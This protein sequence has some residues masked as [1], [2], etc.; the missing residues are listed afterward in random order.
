MTKKS[1]LSISI[2]KDT[3]LEGV[4]GEGGSGVAGTVLEGEAWA[5][6]PC[7][8]WLKGT[9]TVTSE[10]N[11]D[12]MSEG[13]VSPDSSRGA[14]LPPWW[15]VLEAW[16]AGAAR[17]PRVDAGVPTTLGGSD[18]DLAAGT[19]GTTPVALGVALVPATS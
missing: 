18:I 13:L 17:L 14:K 16:S 9:L 12:S 19:E 6:S 7:D 4:L 1:S 5:A 15:G 3:G 11:D 2:T 8:D 10:S